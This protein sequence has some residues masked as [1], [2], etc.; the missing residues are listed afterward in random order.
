ML[1]SLTF[2]LTVAAARCERVRFEFAEGVRSADTVVSGEV[3]RVLTLP[4]DVE[5]LVELERI[6]D[7]TWT[8]GGVKAAEIAVTRVFKGD[9]TLTKLV[10]FA[11]RIDVCDESEGKV[12]DRGYFFLERGGWRDT[13]RAMLADECRSDL[14]VAEILDLG[15]GGAARVLEVVHDDKTLCDLGAH[16]R[17]PTDAKATK[18][19]GRD[20]L[21]EPADIERAIVE[22]VEKQRKPLLELALSWSAAG[23]APWRLKMNR[24]GRVRIDGLAQAA[25]GAFECKLARLYDL[26]RVLPAGELPENGSSIA[27]KGATR[28]AFELTLH[29]SSGPRTYTI[30]VDPAAP[31]ASD[32]AR[33]EGIWLALRRSFDFEPLPAEVV[34]TF[35]V[36]QKHAR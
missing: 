1:T 28:C 21:F 9:P 27:V 6:S 3:V 23:E 26:T 2:V 16:M 12:G 30:Q 5:A 4:L 13:F 8:H 31:A 20:E 29:A 14:G 10:Y 36:Q 15:V 22:T 33:L 7:G 24:E 18:K 19:V 32:G 34:R 25:G 35:D 11:E 17:P